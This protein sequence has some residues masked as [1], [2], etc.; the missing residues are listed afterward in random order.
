M[1]LEGRPTSSDLVNYY[2]GKPIWIFKNGV[3]AGTLNVTALCVGT[4]AVLRTS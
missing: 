2:F 1:A 3:V 4:T